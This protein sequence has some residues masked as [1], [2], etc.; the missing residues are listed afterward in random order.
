MVTTPIVTT[1][2]QTE[3]AG[4]EAQ[5]TGWFVNVE[6]EAMTVFAKIVAGIDVAESELASLFSWIKT[7]GPT[8][9]ADLQ[10]VLAIFQAVGIII[11]NP[12]LIAANAA[13]AGLNAIAA[14]QAA[15]QLTPATAVAGVQAVQ[16]AIAAKSTALLT[17]AP[18]AAVS[19]TP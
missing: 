19:P 11:P 8:V 6:Q 16:Q 1:A 15:G 17:A 12:V 2:F 18:T 3:V 10:Q 14:A 4:F 9:V 5:L 13:V 7:N